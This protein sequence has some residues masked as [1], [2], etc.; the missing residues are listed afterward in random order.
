MCAVSVNFPMMMA[1]RLVQAVGNGMLT[2]MA[3][4]IVLTIFPPEK[5]GTAM[6]W[7]GLS[8]GAAPVIAP[9]IAGIM[10]DTIGWRMI[11]IASLAV[12]M[13]SFVY[14]LAVFAD[15]L[16]NKKQKFD[17]VSFLMSASAFGGITL[18]LGNIG[19][20]G[21]FSI[22]VLSA[23]VFGLVASVLFVNRQLHLEAPFL[24]LRILKN[25]HYTVS[26]LGSMLLYF[27]MMGSSILIP[28]YV[29]QTLGLS[30]T[31]SALVMLPGSLVTAVVGPFAGKIYD[32]IGMKALFIAGSV[33]LILSNALMCTVCMETP[34][35]AAAGYNMIRSMAIGCLMMPLVTWGASNV[36]TEMTAHATALLTSLRTIA[37]AIGSAVF[38]AVMTVTASHS[39]E[40]YEEHASMHGVNAAFLAMAACS[41]VLLILAVVGTGTQT[42]K[43]TTQLKKL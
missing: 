25:K 10:V 30:A 13:I 31:V 19:S 41:I 20:Y 1:G 27:I 18:G 33:C 9:T 23:L 42:D 28:L 15:V 14:A 7:Y 37:G 16:E 34:V 24:E 35:W 5:K 38:V 8:V 21:F 40:S 36:G 6:G 17:I 32:K 29:Q 43:E 12:M 39:A 4:V 11:F 3:Q 26:V 2:S 22:Q